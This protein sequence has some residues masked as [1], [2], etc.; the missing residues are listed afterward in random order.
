MDTASVD[1]QC[2]TLFTSPQK[3][4]RRVLVLPFVSLDLYTPTHSQP[5]Y[6]RYRTLWHI[7]GDG[8]MSRSGRARGLVLQSKQ[9]A[10]EAIQVP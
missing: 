3:A 4:L 8:G 2:Q 9:L 1:C 7:I 6:R 5:R 10:H